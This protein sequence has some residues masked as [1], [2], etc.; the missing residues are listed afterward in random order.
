MPNELFQRNRY[1]YT[2]YFC[3]ENIWWLVHDLVKQGIDPARM[4]V[5]LFSG[6][7]QFV[8]MLNQQA[9]PAGQAQAWDYHVVLLVEDEPGIGSLILDFD[10]RLPFACDL[11]TYLAG[12][13][14]NPADLPPTMQAWV[15]SIPADSY[16]ER[17]SSDRS[18][19]RGVIPETEFPDYP[20]IHPATGLV[21]RLDAVTLAEYRDMQQ[22]LTDG[23]Q[24][25]KL[26]ERFV[27]FYQ[28]L[29]IG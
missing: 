22:Q 14:P 5:L 29:T 26:D 1:R 15:R 25:Q 17:F 7:K 27:D 28:S 9:M 10:T 2:A 11:D 8:F 3:E 18:H 21:S 19:M 12:S 24:L 13:F 6:P 23:S 4:Q 16:L 20:P